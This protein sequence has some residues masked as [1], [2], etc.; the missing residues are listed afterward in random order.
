MFLVFLFVYFQI[1]SKWE[2]D[3]NFYIDR[4]S[5]ILH[6][7][8]FYVWV[9]IKK[10]IWMCESFISYSHLATDTFYFSMQSFGSKHMY[11]C[12][13]ILLVSLFLTTHFDFS[14]LQLFFK[15]CIRSFQKFNTETNVKWLASEIKPLFCFHCCLINFLCSC[16]ILQLFP[17]VKFRNVCECELDK[18]TRWFWLKTKLFNSYWYGILRFQICKKMFKWKN[19]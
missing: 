14:S 3:F 10:N 7:K 18:K 15:L 5:F 19:N 4:Y 1:S 9:S 11:Q 12:I 8:M 13:C 2:S 16:D 6:K 17:L